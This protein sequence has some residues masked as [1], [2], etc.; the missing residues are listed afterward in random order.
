MITLFKFLCTLCAITIL[1]IA[2]Y[3]VSDKGYY[4]CS[5]KKARTASYI[6]RQS[7]KL[8]IGMLCPCMMFIVV[9]CSLLFFGG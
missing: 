1:I 4:I 5:S 7:C 8:M 9:I 3:Y 6:I 2:T